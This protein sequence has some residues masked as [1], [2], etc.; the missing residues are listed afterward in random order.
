MELSVVVKDTQ[1]QVLGFFMQ[2]C[3]G[4]GETLDIERAANFHHLARVEDGIFRIESLGEPQTALGLAER[5]GLPNC[6]IV[7]ARSTGRGCHGSGPFHVLLPHDHGPPTGE[8]HIGRKLGEVELDAL[9]FP[10]EDKRHRPHG[11]KPKIHE[12]VA[13][14]DL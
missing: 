9:L 3:H 7:G 5:V 13:V 12:I 8:R 6:G 2:S 14:A 10:G 4:T 11:I 1:R